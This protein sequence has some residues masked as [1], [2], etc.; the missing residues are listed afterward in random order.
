MADILDQSEVDALLKGVASGDLETE[1]DQ[2][3]SDAE[4]MVYDLTNPE[5]I[6]R[7]KMP[8]LTVV[9]DKFIKGFQASLSNYL[10]KDVEVQILSFDVMK[11]VR[12]IE[13]IPLPASLCMMKV[14]PNN[15]VMIIVMDAQIVFSMM[16]ILCGGTGSSRFK[17]EGRDFTAL[18]QRIIEKVVGRAAEELTAAWKQVV[19]LELSLARMETNPRFVQSVERTETLVIYTL[20]VVIDQITCNMRLCIPYS[21]IEPF[22]TQ[23]SGELQTEKVLRQNQGESQRLQSS[24]K[25]MSVDLVVQVGRGDVTFGDILKLAEGDIIELDRGLDS[26]FDVLSEGIPKFRGFPGQHRSKMAI[27]IHSVNDSWKEK[28]HG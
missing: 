9:H 13:T 3:P 16:D 26:P 6:I 21:T 7:D 11:Y 1:T 19:P 15:G 8:A 17:V 2:P 25:K 27:Q 22:R 10:R 14:A 20:E 28:P 18:E 24:L 5:R 12:F 4:E 23:L